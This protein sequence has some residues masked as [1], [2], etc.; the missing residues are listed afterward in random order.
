MT[1]IIIVPSD[2]EFVM[3]NVVF[4][5][6]LDDGFKLHRL[7]DY[8]KKTKVKFQPPTLQQ[9][10]DYFKEKGYS[11]VGAKKAW[12]YYDSADWKDSKGSQ[13]K[14]WKQKMLGVWMRDEYKVEPIK[15]ETTVQNFFQKG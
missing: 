14:N 2:V 8:D 15:K 13:V 1:K 7:R 10:K 11:E 6:T 12:E 5:Y 4:K 3:N 9:V